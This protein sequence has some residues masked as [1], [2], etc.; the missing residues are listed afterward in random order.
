MARQH[1]KPNF[2]HAITVYSPTLDT[3]LS[4]TVIDLLDTQFIIHLTK[5]LELSGKDQFIFYDDAWAFIS[6]SE[7]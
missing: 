3:Q 7:L 1:R 6:R 4:G 5:P 2:G